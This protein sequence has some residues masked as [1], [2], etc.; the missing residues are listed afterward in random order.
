MTDL[1]GKHVVITGASTG[2]GRAS[3]TSCAQAGAAVTLIARR[4]DL[5]E[6]AAAA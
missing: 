2:I 3:A 4:A 5:L 1:A 6:Q